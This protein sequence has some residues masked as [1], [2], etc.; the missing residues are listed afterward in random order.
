VTSYLKQN[1]KDTFGALAYTTSGQQFDLEVIVEFQGGTR[2]A[3][4]TGSGWQAMDGGSV[5]PAAGS[6]G[7]VYYSAPVEDLNAE[8]YPFGFDTPSFHPGAGWGAPAVKAAVTNLTPLPTANM[9]LAQHHP[10]KATR[11]AIG[12]Y[13]IDFGT[14]TDTPSATPSSS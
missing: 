9:I 7:T 12:H 3:W 10:V 11:I 2:V 1:T 4:G 14:P 13:L 6:I 5:Y 8:R